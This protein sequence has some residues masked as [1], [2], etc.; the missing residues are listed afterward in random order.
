MHT[1]R[2]YY[3]PVDLTYYYKV[4]YMPDKSV[5]IPIC[6]CETLQHAVLLANCLNGGELRD[7]I[8]T[9]INVMQPREDVSIQDI[10]VVGLTDMA[11]GKPSP[12]EVEAS[13]QQAEHKPDSEA[14][15]KHHD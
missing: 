15:T 11:V 6:A 13:E 8:G 14:D 12:V 3:G 1:V 10:P 2:M 7:S 5:F 4:G 9:Y